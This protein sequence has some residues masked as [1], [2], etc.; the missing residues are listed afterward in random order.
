MGR[1]F[2]AAA[3]LAAACLAAASCSWFSGTARVA[4]RLPE[5][6]E[7]WRRAF[8][9]LEFLLVAPSGESI[10]G[11]LRL[12]KEPNWPV[13][14]VPLARG[15]RLRP[16]GALWPWD[17]DGQTLVLTWE[18]G[19]AAEVFAALV[20]EGV[21]V[22]AL[23]GER[24]LEQMAARGGED[25]WVLDLSH[26]ASRL[27]VGEFRVTDLRALP[28]RDLQL[29]LPPGGWLLDSPFRPALQADDAGPLRLL[30]VP[31]GRHL[32]LPL[33][34]PGVFSLY[35]REHDAVLVPLPP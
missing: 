16:A 1:W 15:A 30:G 25:P 17:L 23:D 5:P 27:A 21:D 7:H 29:Q 4:V 22:T 32:L 3:W 11:G 33:Q 34:P 20:R 28:R 35:V 2:L 24:L 19:P 8:P 18:H 31:L 6:P 13:Q 26:L 14:A 10:P 12:P 9:E